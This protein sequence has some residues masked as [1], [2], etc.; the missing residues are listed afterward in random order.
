MGR[1][2]WGRAHAG[3][4][5]SPRAGLLLFHA[6]SR[7]DS[8]RR[9]CARPRGRQYHTSTVS[10]RCWCSIRGRHARAARS[11]PA[12]PFHSGERAAAASRR[13]AIAGRVRRR[14][15]CRTRSACGTSRGILWECT[16]AANAYTNL[17]FGGE[18]P[19]TTNRNCPSSVW[20]SVRAAR[21]PCSPTRSP[22]SAFY[23]RPLGH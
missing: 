22:G 12:V 2:V 23:R 5:W 6:S 9:P 3:H 15:R 1:S 10:K 20:R 8:Y 18:S 21:S 7:D 16:Q 14:R 19:S 4:S 11:S 13:P 17:D